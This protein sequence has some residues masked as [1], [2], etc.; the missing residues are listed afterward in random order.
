MVH[1]HVLSYVITCYRYS[2]S[3]YFIAL[4]IADTLFLWT[5]LPD[6]TF[7]FLLNKDYLSLSDIH[8]RFTSWI[9]YSSAAMSAWTIVN[10]TIERVVLTIWPV[11]AYLKLSPKLSLKI[12]IG[13]ALLIQC[14]TS[15]LLFTHTMNTTTININ[16]SSSQTTKKCKLNTQETRDFMNTSWNYIVLICFNVL[17][18][19]TIISGNMVI[20]TVL[21]KS[22]RQIHPKGTL[23]QTNLTREKQA[24]KMLLILSCFFVVCTCPYCVYFVLKSRVN[25]EKEIAVDALINVSVHILLFSNF[26]FNFSLYFVRGKLFRQEWKKIT[27]SMSNKLSVMKER[28]ISKKRKTTTGTVQANE[29][30]V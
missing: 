12:S 15:H 3:V 5:A 16:N 24:V 20:G 2:T 28:L 22:K 7:R 14:L 30:T 8:C 11:K 19:V 10:L 18:M 27:L 6:A 25:G 26:T 17:P 4:A 21:F 9:A 13:T 23:I 1:T 29:T